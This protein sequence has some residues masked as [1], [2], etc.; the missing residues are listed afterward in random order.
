VTATATDLFER[1]DGT[2]HEDTQVG[3]RGVDLTVDRVLEVVRP[4]RVDF[5]SGELS[6]AGLTARRTTKRHSDD[7][8]AW[9]TLT[10][11]TYLLEFN[12]SLTGDTPV[13][14]EPGRGLLER[15]VSHPTV[16]TTDLHRVPLSV[17]GAGL[18]LK[19]NARVSTVYPAE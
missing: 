8:Y 10:A 4:G 16:T 14:L 17:G 2:V 9:W 5:G 3:E 18:K 19:E 13:R 15:G 1:L 12:E 7:E 6:S 11:G